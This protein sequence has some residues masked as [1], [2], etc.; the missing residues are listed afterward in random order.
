M[1]VLP[2][3][4]AFHLNAKGILDVAKQDMAY[5]LLV[6]L[7]LPAWLTGF[8][9]AVMFGAILSSF[10]S[11]LNSVCTLFSV[12]IY[13]QLI[14]KSAPD[15]EL[16]WIGKLFGAVLIVVCIL[17]APLIAEAPEG[18]YTLMRKTM[19]FFNIPILAIVLMGVLSKRAP[20]QA[21]YL[22]VPIGI[23]FYG[24]FGFYKGG[25][26]FGVQVHWLHVTGINLALMMTLM[27]I[28]RLIKPMEK[29]YVQVYT[30]EVDL[31][32]WK[33]AKAAGVGIVALVIL[34]YWWLGR[35]G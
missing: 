35:F 16:V 14:R 17:L 26:M 13:K 9:G 33:G 29:P 12:D 22:A 27:W 15:T 30:G 24:Y 11:G 7:V 10:N 8:F 19:A 2:G 20:A 23:I 3:I 31:T 4:I 5:P 25:D 32:F 21:A 1:L 34:V 28:V 6:S 18:L